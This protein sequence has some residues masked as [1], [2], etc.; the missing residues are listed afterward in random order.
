MKINNPPSP[1][2]ELKLE[3]TEIL[4]CKNC[5]STNFAQGVQLRRVSPIVSPTGQ[6]GIVP[7]PQFYCVE[8]NAVIS[9]ESDD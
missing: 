5:G 2:Q 8:C 9:D 4:K 3:D 7:L 1:Q 6:E